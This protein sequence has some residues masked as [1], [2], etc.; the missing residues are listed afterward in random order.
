MFRKNKIKL[1]V[2]LFVFLF[3]QFFGNF[4]FVDKVYAIPVEDIP[5][6]S[7]FTAKWTY[8]KVESNLTAAALGSLVSG[9]SY[10][11]RKLAYDGAKYIAAG[12]KG[13]GA[14]VFTQSP[15][16]YFT[17]VASDSLSEAIG[18]LG[19]PF[20]LNLCAPPDLSVLT[21]LK[22]SLSKIY[23]NI[24][25]FK[26]APGGKSLV[27]D[28]PQANCTWANFQNNWEKLP[29]QLG[30][31]TISERFAKSLNDVTKTDFGTA[32]VALAQLDQLATD[33]KE[34]ALVERLEGQGFKA[35]TT[36]ISGA[37][38]SPASQV[39]EEAKALTAKEQAQ[40]SASQV[41]GLYSSQAWPVFASALSIFINTLG[42]SL[43]DRI[44]N[45][46]LVT[47]PTGDPLDFGATA[48]NNNRVAAEKAF[49]FLI[50]GLPQISQSSY[51]IIAQYSA[52]P[53]T[54]PGLNNCVMDDGLVQA[55]NREGNPLTIK[56]A[57]DPSVGLL[58]GDWY[59]VPKLDVVQNT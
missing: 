43:L 4:L 30:N 29:D 18:N 56:E 23:N 45:K 38:K 1:S 20:G 59:L 10:F 19:T 48:L 57:M 51:N 15:G 34:A 42:S 28:G 40:Q 35:V 7:A 39:Q 52:C 11:L 53:P 25:S 33:K 41:A 24:N 22:V 37:I 36:L 8:D 17:T 50:A 47:P 55:L 14:L 13:Q 16:D 21:S 9:I 58:H 44:L 6:M 5:L 2:L 3:V 26:P 46:G 32:L 49:S 31:D 27:P 12:G 54:N